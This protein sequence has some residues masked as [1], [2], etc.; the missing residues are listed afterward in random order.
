MLDFIVG[1]RILVGLAVAACATS[2]AAEDKEVRPVFDANGSVHVPAFDLPPSELMSPEATEFMKMRGRMPM[3]APSTQGDIGDSRR[4][5]EAMLAPQV[6]KM[7]DLYPVDVVDQTIANV[8]TRVVTPKGKT[9][10]KDRVLI[11]LHGGAFSVCADAC[12]MLESVP[13]A[14]LGGFKIVT[15]NYRMAPEATHPA[16]AE[17]VAAVYRELLKSYKPKQIGIYGCSA[18]GALTGQMAA[19][20]PAHGLPQAGAI[21]IFG[22]GAVR[23][24][25]GDSAYVAGY[26]DGSFPPPP[27][28]GAPPQPPIDRGYFAQT[29]LRDP[30]VSPALHP[31]VLAKFPPSLIITGSRAMDM[32]P[33]IYTNTQL[34]KAGV[35][36]TLLVAEGMSHCYM[37]M[38]NL[39]ESRD[40]Y[41]ITVDFFRENLR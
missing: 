24:G 6:A 20:L 9:A 33:A 38:P 10:V 5:L 30:I 4:K 16:A 19:W 11:N 14:S 7:R 22:A 15:V 31:D 27:T 12:A 39:P 40:A 34:L 26:I 2:F 23:F 1:R 8:P 17:D 28:P 32:S 35:R 41:Q 37:Y 3:R 36:S 25:S 21:G 29:D 18:G 13:I